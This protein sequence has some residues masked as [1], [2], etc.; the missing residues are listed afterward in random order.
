MTCAY[1]ADERQGKGG[2]RSTWWKRQTCSKGK[3]SNDTQYFCIQPLGR[4][5]NSHVPHLCEDSVAAVCLVRTSLTLD[6]VLLPPARVSHEIHG[7]RAWN[8]TSNVRDLASSSQMLDS[9]QT[10]VGLLVHIIISCLAGKSD[11]CI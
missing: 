2:I 10:V 11:A 4:A 6:I 3:N 7:A 1:L 5:V 9:K 8:Q